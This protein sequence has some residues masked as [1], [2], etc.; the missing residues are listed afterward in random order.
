V[1]FCRLETPKRGQGLSEVHAALVT[2]GTD[3]E[4]LTRESLVTV[5]PIE[6]LGVSIWRW[7]IQELSAKGEPEA[8][9]A[10][11]HEA[12][13]A[14]FGK[15]VGKNVDKESANEFVCF[16]SH[17]SDAVVL[18]SIPVLKC[19]LAVLKCQQAVIGDGDAVCIAAEVIE[20]LSGSAKGRFGIDDPFVLAVSA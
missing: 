15:A 18:F 19:H 4:G 20:D 7:S 3:I 14:D 6:E 9:M 11:G 17:G 10:V 16:E 8:T 13:V 2:H 5:F 1:R 12:E